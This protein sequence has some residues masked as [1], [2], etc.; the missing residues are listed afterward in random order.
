MQI[1]RPTRSKDRPDNMAE[2]I[3]QQLKND[4]FEFRLLPGDRFSETDVAE[5]VE[6]SRTPV[7]QA[8]YRL[9]REGYLEVY[10]RSGWQVRPFDFNYFEELYDVRIVLETAALA[11]LGQ[12]DIEA[13]PVLE[14]L[15]RLWL[16]PASE[17]LADTQQVSALDERFH[18]ALVQATG[19]SEMARMHFEITEKIRI[20]RRLDFTQ[21]PRINATYEEHGQILTAI[22]QRRTEQAQQLLK[23]HIEISKKE[24]RKITIHMLHMARQRA[25]VESNAGL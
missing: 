23:S 10:F 20:I 21:V 1:S 13:N 12:A 24:V 19:N 15:R 4:I 14:E 17:R 3:Y 16:V 8:L 6:A 7:R 9:E 18:C 2:R 11:R 22:F 25:Y 5:R